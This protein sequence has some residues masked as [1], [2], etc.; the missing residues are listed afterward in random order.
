VYI[1]GSLYDIIRRCG[2]FCFSFFYMKYYLYN[3]MLPAKESIY[4]HI[5]FIKLH[6]LAHPHPM[7]SSVLYLQGKGTLALNI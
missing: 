1:S 6:A 5:V 4:K 3:C 7:E 2:S